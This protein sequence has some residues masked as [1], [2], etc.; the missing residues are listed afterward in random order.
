MKELYRWDNSYAKLPD[1]MHARVIPEPAPVAELLGFNHDLAQQLGMVSTPTDQVLA[2]TFSG[3]IVPEGAM[4]ISQAYAGHQFG[5]FVPSLGDGRAVLLGE[6]VNTDGVRRDIQLKGSGKTPFSRGGDGKAWL[7]PVLREYVVS[8]AMHHL[9]IPTTR[10]LAAVKTGETIVRAEGY[11]PGAVVTRVASSH[12]R[13]G[14]FQYFAARGDKDAVQALLD[15]SIARHYPESASPLEFLNAVIE[16]QASLISKWLGV[17]FIHGV[18]NTDN[19]T[20]SGETIDYGP[21]AFM[22]RYHPATVFSSIDRHGRYAYSNQPDIIV[23][24]LAQLAS[25]LLILEADQDT[26]IEAYTQAVHNMPEMLESARLKVFGRKLGI[27]NAT[28]ADAHLIGQFLEILSESEAD[29]TNSFSG[30]SDE[31]TLS[32]LTHAELPNWS[33]EWQKRLESEA[34]PVAV[35]NAANPI[36]IPR[37]HRIEEMIQA[38]LTG[39]LGPFERLNRVLANPYEQQSGGDDLTL[40]P[41]ADEEIEATFCGT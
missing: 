36:Y 30:L 14:T 41:T 27:A 31:T 38:A 5:N 3:K 19:T 35:M 26:A 40:P 16:R 33:R 10:A 39:D 29:F 18:M 4:P 11:M 32:L 21:C 24:N 15:Y 1:R 7:G 13:V 2:D 17:G 23:W 12:I 6:V 34:D 37:N 20:I 28:N 8:E 25:S 22:D 9:G